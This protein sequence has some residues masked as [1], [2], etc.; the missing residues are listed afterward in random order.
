MFNKILLV[1]L[2]LCFSWSSPLRA[3]D[4][5]AFRST[6]LPLPRFVSL[7]SDKVYA[8]SGPALRYP[9]KWV[10]QKNDLPVEITQEYDTWRKIRDVD[11]DEGWIHQSLLT[12]ERTAL[13]RS[14]QMTPM[15]EGSSYTTRMVARL[16]PGVVGRIQKCTKQ[17]CKLE[18]GGYR[19][20]IE[21]KFLWG[22]YDHEVIE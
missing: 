2:V 21:R 10:Y 20:W 16:E 13:V 5:K 18:A 11:G 15:Q 1:L 9:I 14:D 17:W 6:D 8:R 12:G 19:G 22:I 7:R 4:V 3:E